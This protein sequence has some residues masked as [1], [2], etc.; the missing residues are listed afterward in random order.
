MSARHLVPYGH[1]PLHGDVNLDQLDHP[2][3]ELVSALQSPHPFVVDFLE[4]LH[5]LFR[6]AFHFDQLFLI[7]GMAEQDAPQIIVR[8]LLQD[9]GTQ[10]TLAL[11]NH[12]PGFR[13]NDVAADPLPVEEFSHLFYFLIVND[14]K[15]V[16]VIALQSAD[17]VAFVHLRMLGLIAAL[18]RK[19]F[20]IDDDPFHPRRHN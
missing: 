6:H 20:N 11:Q 1:L 16:L 18:A 7:F 12:I 8:Y 13:I 19:N 14:A 15:L 9:I 10:F 5:L 3:R 2:G 4:D 17:I